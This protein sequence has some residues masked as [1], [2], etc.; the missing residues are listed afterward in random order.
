MYRLQI[1][2][3]AEED[4]NTL[5]RDEPKAAYRI[6]A[7]LQELEADQGLLDRLTQHKYGTNHEADFEVS[8]WFAFW[9]SG[10]DI[11]LV[12]IWDLESEGLPYRVIYSYSPGLQIYT[13]LG[14]TH[15]SFNYE[16]NHPITIRI[17]LAYESL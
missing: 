2:P 16:K 5:L 1:H 15:R 9:N 10:K 7:L 3:D 8:K 17:N 14:I 11:W 6:A 13:V 4:L 12:K